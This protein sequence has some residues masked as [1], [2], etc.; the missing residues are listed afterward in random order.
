MSL[1]KKKLSV[2]V[3][4]KALKRA[5]DA[6]MIKWYPKVN[7]TDN[8]YWTIT[9]TKPFGFVHEKNEKVWHMQVWIWDTY[10]A[11]LVCEIISDDP[12]SMLNSPYVD[13]DYEKVILRTEESIAIYSFDGNLIKK[14]GISLPKN[15]HKCDCKFMDHDTLLI[16]ATIG[17]IEVQ[18]DKD[19]H[20]NYWLVNTSI[21]IDGDTRLIT[22]EGKEH[23]VI[24]GKFYKS[25]DISYTIT[26]WDTSQV[27]NTPV[28]F[29]QNRIGLNNYQAIHSNLLVQINLASYSPEMPVSFENGYLKIGDSM[30][31]IT[32][33]KKEQE[34]KK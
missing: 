17:P 29:S 4:E 34:Q 21:K 12:F 6:N 8:R 32:D 5:M 31:A 2:D 30:I 11:K 28:E 9:F 3:N 20:Y 19:F 24:I 14:Y 16:T 25:S 18:L 15:G 13:T 7:M 22:D 1:P 26:L 10:F 33:A 23:T 27:K